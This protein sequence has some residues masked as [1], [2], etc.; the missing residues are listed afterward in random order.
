MQKEEEEVVVERLSYSRYLAI[1]PLHTLIYLYLPGSSQAET[2]C[3]APFALPTAVSQ[4]QEFYRLALL[5]RLLFC[6]LFCTLLQ[7]TQFSLS[8]V[9]PLN[10]FAPKVCC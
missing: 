7:C 9:A 6:T 2:D 1:P 10:Y 4:W 8:T 5:R 3:T